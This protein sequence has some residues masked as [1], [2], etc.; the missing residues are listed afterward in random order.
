M[1][2]MHWVGPGQSLLDWQASGGRHRPAVHLQAA[3]Q[4][5]S[6]MQADGTQLFRSHRSPVGQSE[7]I[8]HSG[9]G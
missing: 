2:L 6:A 4:S 8:W 1:L 3:G 9:F 5:E 7:S